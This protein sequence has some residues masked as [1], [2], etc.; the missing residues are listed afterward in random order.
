MHLIERHDFAVASP[1][2]SGDAPAVFEDAVLVVVGAEAAVETGIDPSEI[3]P[4]RVKNPWRIP[5]RLERFCAS[6]GLSM[7][8][9]AIGT[10]HWATAADDCS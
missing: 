1:E 9:T 4:W 6:I 7:L 2:C 5:A 3:P 8:V 10:R